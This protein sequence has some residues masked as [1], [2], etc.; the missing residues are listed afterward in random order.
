ME[1]NKQTRSI[2]GLVT[3]ISGKDTIK[4]T[5]KNRKIHPIYKKIVNTSVSFLAHAENSKSIIIGDK[6]EITL[7]RPI[8]KRK[9]WRFVRVIEKAKAVES[10]SPK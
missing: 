6:V 2:M 5:V 7:C 10:K 9:K 4:V 8:S 3:S 1:N